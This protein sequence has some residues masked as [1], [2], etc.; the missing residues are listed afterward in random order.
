MIKRVRCGKEFKDFQL[1][2]RNVVEKVIGFLDTEQIVNCAMQGYIQGHKTG[3][4]TMNLVTGKLVSDS[5]G[6]NERQHPWEAVYV[7][8]YK[9]SQNDSVYD[10]NFN[11]DI[12]DDT[13]FAEY[14]KM[15]ERQEVCGIEDYAEKKSINLEERFLETLVYYAEGKDFLNEVKEE[16]DEW[17]QEE[18]D[19][20]NCP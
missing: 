13:E 18:E 8:L 10:F 17:Y 3:F 7:S 15:L 6:A 2:P 1:L 14:E 12:L 4:A 19:F 11:G 16:L 20:A 9:I 5:L